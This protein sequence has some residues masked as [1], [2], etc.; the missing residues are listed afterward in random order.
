MEEIPHTQSKRI[1][2]KARFIIRVARIHGPRGKNR[3]RH[4]HFWLSF[5]YQE[6]IPDPPF[7]MGTTFRDG[8]FIN[9]NP[10]NVFLVCLFFV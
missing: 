8:L 6:L 3:P 7:E 9:I 4:F 1:W 2:H 5:T 10:K